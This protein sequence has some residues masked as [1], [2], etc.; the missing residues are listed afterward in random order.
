MCG[1]SRT[2]GTSFLLLFTTLPPVS[3]GLPSA[4]A[5][6]ISMALFPSSR[7]SLNTVML[8]V[9]WMMRMAPASSASWPVMGTLPA[10]PCDARAWMHPPAVPSF[11]ARTASTLFWFAVS[12]CSHSFCASEGCQSLTNWSITILMSPLSARGWMYFI[13]PAR[14]SL[15]LLSVGEPARTM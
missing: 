3:T 12:A 4:M 14:N 13:A 2:E 6:A 11:G 5:T 8:W 1:V 9:P 7:V 10:R 15:A